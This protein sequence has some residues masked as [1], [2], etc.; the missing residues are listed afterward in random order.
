MSA[1]ERR[2]LEIPARYPEVIGVAATNHKGELAFYSNLGDVRAPGGEP[3]AVADRG[4]KKIGNYIG[5]INDNYYETAMISYSKKHGEMPKLA[6]WWGTSF[7]TPLVSG[8]AALMLEK[9]SAHGGLPP[10]D[11]ERLIVDNTSERVIDVQK[12]LKALDE[13]LSARA[14]PP[15]T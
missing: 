9:A 8:L 12:T 10:K 13:Y 11:V 14:A 5:E 15:A 3:P 2:P 1:Y 6:Y 4:K 7:A